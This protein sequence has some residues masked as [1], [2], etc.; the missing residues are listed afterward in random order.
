MGM[1][2]T[3]ES[4]QDNRPWMGHPN[5]VVIESDKYDTSG[6]YLYRY[7]DNNNCVGDTWHT[8]LDDALDQA[9]YEYESNLSKWHHIPYEVKDIQEFIMETE[10]ISENI[11]VI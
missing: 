1:P 2:S 4:I 3:S 8:T 9:T 6:F 11:D 5:L 7:D 10:R